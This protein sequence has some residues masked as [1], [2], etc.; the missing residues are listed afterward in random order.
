MTTAAGPSAP[1]AGAGMYEAILRRLLAA[2]VMAPHDRVLVQF[3]GT[4]DREITERVGLRRCTFVNLAP[5]SPSSGL[6]DAVQA[7]AHRMDVP[8][9]GYD[10]VIGH[11]GL[12][13]CSRPHQALHE[14]Y[15]IARRTVVAV[16]NQDSPLMRLAC[17]YGLAGTYEFLAV[18]DGGG[19]SGGVDGTGVP[20]HVY[21]WT[22]HEVRK[23]VRTFDPSR[24]VPVEFDAQWLIG[25]DRALTP[26][27]RAVLG[28]RDTPA[29]GLRSLAGRA[30]NGGLNGVVRHQGNIFGFVIR[31]DLA[32]YHPW[33]ASR[34]AASGPVSPA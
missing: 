20:N 34:D 23:T 15:R 8:D 31:K 19:T 5:E 4:F 22:R 13:H 32:R 18:S 21:R 3:A 12:H 17:R 16:E 28:E 30:I 26:G 25:P 1:E 10:H 27:M 29:G 11:A 24:E 2:A 9:G 7:D 14:M 6:D 33:I